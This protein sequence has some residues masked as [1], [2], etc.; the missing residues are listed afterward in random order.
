MKVKV[1]ENLP[2]EV[3][4]LFLSDASRRPLSGCSGR[5]FTRARSLVR[6]PLTRDAVG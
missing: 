3:A 1:D 2:H 4:D 6:P 5:S